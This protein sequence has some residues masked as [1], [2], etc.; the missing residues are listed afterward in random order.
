MKDELDVMPVV[1]RRDRT[2]MDTVLVVGIHKC[3][4]LKVAQRIEA[5]REV[6]ILLSCL[7]PVAT[8]MIRS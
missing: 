5:K 6:L 3:L 4:L 8:P 1:E 2:I 7:E